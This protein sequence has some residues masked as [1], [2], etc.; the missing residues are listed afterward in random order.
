[1]AQQHLDRLTAIDASFLAQEG[2]ASHMHIGGVVLCEGPAPRFEEILDHI[3]SRLHLVPRYRQRLAEPPLEAGRPLWVDDPTFNLEYHVRQTALPAPGTE[4]QLWRLVGRL[5]SQQLDRSKPLWEMWIV[6]GLERGGFA[7]LSKTHHSLIDGISGVDLATVM[8]DVTPVPAEVPH[9]DEPWRPHREPTPVDLVA[10]GAIGLAKAAAA[11]VAGV[12]GAI[13]RPQS[14]LRA[15]TEAAEGVGE[16]VWAGLNPAP[17]TPLNVEIGPHRRYTVVRNSLADFKLIK[18]AFGG[19]VND[20]VLTVVSGALR[21]WLH[22]RGVRTEGVELR[23][24]VPVSTRGNHEANTLGNRIAAMRAPLPVYIDDP[25]ARLRAVKLAMDGLKESKQA[26][27]AEVLTGVQGF[28]PPT[29][30]AQASRLNFST[31]LFNLI[32]TNVPGPQLPLYV[33]GREMTDVFPV[34]FLP[35]NHALAVAIMS[36]NG[37]MN[38]GLLGDYDALSDLEDFAEGIR[39]SLAELVALARSR[40]SPPRA[41]GEA[42]GASANGA[43][44]RRGAGARG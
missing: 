25:V 12:L 31:R 15:A 5:M 16:V 28:A 23:A 34:A 21:A 41:A 20:V 42:N 3:R 19:T 24:L 27:G 39:T 7:L 36:Y 38:F 26:V 32:V 33:R 43:S 30:L 14:A 22:G 17:A 44:A 35:K 18:N 11:G 13:A 29:I 40:T 37:Q 6:E 8:F 1:M 4:D 10:G 9:P 2:P